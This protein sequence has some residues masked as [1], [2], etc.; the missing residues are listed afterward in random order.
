MGNEHSSSRNTTGFPSRYEQLSHVDDAALVGHMQTGDG[1]A[2][3]VL[4]DRYYNLVLGTALRIL[5]D[6]GEA[7]DVLQN[8]FVEIFQSAGQFDPLRGTFY[9]W[10]MQYAYHRSLNRKNYLVARQFYANVDVAELN[11]FEQTLHNLYSQPSQE[12]TRFVREALAMLDERQRRT[13]EM[14][15][16]EGLTLKAVAEQ[17]QESFS[18]VRHQ[19]YRGLAQLKEHLKSVATGVDGAG[20]Q[21]SSPNLEVFRAKA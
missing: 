2:L 12:C 10:L 1:D 21:S 20:A 8:V 11:E 13:I 4:F 5:R 16:Y 18:A 7:E 6:R 15:H 3:A 14:V 19:Y 9:V 17:S